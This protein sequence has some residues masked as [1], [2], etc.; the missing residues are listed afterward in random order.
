MSPDAVAAAR[1]PVLLGVRISAPAELRPQAVPRRVPLSADLTRR[2]DCAALKHVMGLPG[3]P[4]YNSAYSGRSPY[5][6]ER[7]GSDAATA[8]LPA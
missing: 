8:L 1:A 4:A 3:G 6:V 5:Q 2:M 7:V